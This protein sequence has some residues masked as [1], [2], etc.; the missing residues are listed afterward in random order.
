MENAGRVVYG[1]Q[2]EAKNQ[3]LTDLSRN[4]TRGMTSLA[5]QGLWAAGKPA[6]GYVAVDKRLV[7]G[8]PDD[9]ALVR[10]MFEAYVGGKSLRGLAGEMNQRGI[11]SPKNTPWTANGI[12][13]VLCNRVYS[14][15]Y[16]LN[17]PCL[18]KYKRKGRPERR[19][20]PA[21][22]IVYENH[23]PAIIDRGTF[24]KAQDQL[25]ARKNSSTPLP[26]GGGFV[27]SGVLV[28]GKCGHN[29][30]GDKAN[31]IHHYTCYGYRQRG[32]DYCDRNSLRQDDILAGVLDGMQEKYFNPA[33]MKALAES[34][35]RQLAEHGRK[36]DSNALRRELAALDAK[37]DKAKRRLVEVDSDMLP[38]VQDHIRDLRQ[39]Q[40][41][42]NDR[43]AACEGSGRTRAGDIEERIDKAL[44]WFANLREA[45][46]KGEPTLLR[47][48]IREAME[49]IELFAEKIPWTEKRFKYRLD[50]G[51]VILKPVQNAPDIL[52]M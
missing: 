5:E 37:L 4:V 10:W 26:N 52:A 32:S 1:I 41:A 25:K 30:I 40:S 50:R 12:A 27:L 24:D 45:A 36:P 49:R 31:G 15:E 22:W 21:D 44:A 47:Q 13:S 38:D 7:L 9:V 46:T 28:C 8:E 43:L 20:D 39:K 42:L 18:S 2:Q 23:H 14:G 19:N 33:T 48:T 35:R 29:M 11:L 34:M 17:V 3:Y 51:V 6:F 16:R